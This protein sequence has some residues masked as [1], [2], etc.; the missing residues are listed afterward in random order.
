MLAYIG[1]V[2]N[3]NCVINRQNLIEQASGGMKQV[4]VKCNAN[5]LPV[6]TVTT[7]NFIN[8]L[9][10]IRA[11]HAITRNNSS[12]DKRSMRSKR[13]PVSARLSLKWL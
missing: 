1:P 11:L 2:P 6:T 4:A 8:Y 10:K 9:G 12:N 13:A 5:G 7:I 3:N